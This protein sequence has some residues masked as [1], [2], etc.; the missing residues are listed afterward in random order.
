MPKPNN[1]IA[2]SDFATFP[3]DTLGNTISITLA[4]G[5][6][7]SI[8]NPSWTTTAT[9][10]APKSF[11]RARML[12]SLDNK[13]GSGTGLFSLINVS[14][15]DGGTVLY[16]G[17][18]VLYCNLDKISDTSVQLKLWLEG[19]GPPSTY[20]YRL[21]EAVTVTFIYSTFINPLI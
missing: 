17:D 21:N 2:S 18:M 15:M 13:W 6:Q 19:F 14:I 7:I 16:T 5:T 8:N 11:L 20:K 10:G 1:F 3:S 9:G 4:S 12:C